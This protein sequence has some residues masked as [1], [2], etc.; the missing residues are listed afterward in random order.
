MAAPSLTPANNN[1]LQVY[2]Y[3]AQNSGSPSI[4]EPAAIT[5]RANVTSTKED[6]AIALGDLAAPSM[7]NPSLTYDAT[8]SGSGTVVLS[9]QAV[10]LKGK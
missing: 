1:E 8:G 7:G 2:F 4:S 3:G 6:V 10:L 5:S 9:A